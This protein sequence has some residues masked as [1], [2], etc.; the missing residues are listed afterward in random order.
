MLGMMS[1]KQYKKMAEE[2]TIE[3]LIEASE[4]WLKSSIKYFDL[5]GPCLIC[6]TNPYAIKRIVEELKLKIS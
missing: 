3:E 2:A 1:A 5:T 6:G 4:E